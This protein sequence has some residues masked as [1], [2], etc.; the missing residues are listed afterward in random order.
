MIVADTGQLLRVKELRAA[1]LLTPFAPVVIPNLVAAECVRYGIDLSAPTFDVRSEPPPDSALALVASHVRAGLIQPAE[2]EA[3][4]WAIYD[5]A[6]WLLT[7]DSRARTI[8]TGLGVEV[9]GSVGLILRN[10]Q[11]GH[12]EF[13]RARDLLAGLRSSNLWVSGRILAEADSLLNAL[14]HHGQLGEEAT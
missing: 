6:D 2:A 9:H 5:R 13:S 10:A 8:S 14:T 12:I 1:D 7:D 4:A 3:I 11:L